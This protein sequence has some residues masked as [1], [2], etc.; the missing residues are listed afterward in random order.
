MT[1][2]EIEVKEYLSNR[3]LGL[4]FIFHFPTSFSLN[5]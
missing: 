1:R 2:L 3:R 4:T 5:M